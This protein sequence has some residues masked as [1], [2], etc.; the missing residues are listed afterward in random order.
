[1]ERTDSNGLSSLC[2]PSL[3]RKKEGNYEEKY[4]EMKNSLIG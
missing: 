4:D 1:M 3:Q 2:I